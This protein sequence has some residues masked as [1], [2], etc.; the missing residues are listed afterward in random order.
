MKSALTQ[1]SNQRNPRLPREMS[2]FY[3]FLWGN[4]ILSSSIPIFFHLFNDI[5]QKFSSVSIENIKYPVKGP[6]HLASRM[7]PG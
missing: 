6:E 1:C 2:L 3:L 4:P 7:I 5:H